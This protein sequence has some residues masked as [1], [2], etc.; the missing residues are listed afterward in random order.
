MTTRKRKAK[1]KKTLVAGGLFPGFP[2]TVKTL[3]DTMFA[4]IVPHI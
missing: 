1:Q 4:E 2:Q 3:N